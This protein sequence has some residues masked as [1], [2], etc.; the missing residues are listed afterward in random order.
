MAKKISIVIIILAVILGGVGIYLKI[1]SN[2]QEKVKGATVVEIGNTPLAPEKSFDAIN[3]ADSAI[4]SSEATP[5]K[6]VPTIS[7][8]KAEKGPYPMEIDAKKAYEAVLKTT[9]GDITIELNAAATPITVNNFVA[10]SRKKYYDKTFL[11]I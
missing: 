7:P 11:E 2:D 1:Y 3:V 4:S 8:S 6:R 9:V 10:L 5:A